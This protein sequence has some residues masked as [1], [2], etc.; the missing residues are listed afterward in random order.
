MSIDIT[1][2]EV[3]KPLEAA[4]RADDE[5]SDAD[6]FDIIGGISAQSGRVGASMCFHVRDIIK[7]HGAADLSYTD[8]TIQA[9]WR[10]FFSPE[11]AG[12]YGTD[13]WVHLPA[14]LAE[15]AAYLIDPTSTEVTHADP[16]PIPTAH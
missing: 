15:F 8:I 9:Y 5:Y 14:K 4:I 7:E 1:N 16:A 11:H 12:K 6:L 13:E 2:T 10:T 3:F